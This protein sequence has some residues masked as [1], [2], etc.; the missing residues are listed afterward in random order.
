MSLHEKPIKVFL[1][2]VNE[3]GINDD[4]CH[5]CTG[6][7]KLAMKNRRKFLWYFN[8]HIYYYFKEPNDMYKRHYEVSKFFKDYVIHK[9]KK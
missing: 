8:S 2:Q 7:I 1:K 9:V 3:L 4:S 5:Y 6:I